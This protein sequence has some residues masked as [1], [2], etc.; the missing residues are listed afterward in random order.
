M[1]GLYIC[2]K[3]LKMIRERK[4]ATMDTLA[5]G[6]IT[7]FTNFKE[8]RARITEQEYLE[9]VVKNLLESKEDS[10]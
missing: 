7:D 3:L 1:D 10:D 8:V 9:Q 2:E 4:K 6:A 5:Y